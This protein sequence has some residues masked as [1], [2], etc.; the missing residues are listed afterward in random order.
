MK[1]ASVSVRNDVN[2]TTPLMES[3]S[4]VMAVIVRGE[5]P[6]LMDLIGECVISKIRAISTAVRTIRVGLQTLETWIANV[7]RGG[8]ENNVRLLFVNKLVYTASA[9]HPTNA[10]ALL[11]GLDENVKF[12]SVSQSV[13]TVLASAPTN[14]NAILDGLDHNVKQ[15]STNVS[16]T[17]EA[18]PINASTM[19]VRSSVGAKVLTL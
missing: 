11:D 8:L 7:L 3:A 17:K 1:S 10:N 16:I 4:P 19:M 14:A 2:P 12:L 18:V 6:G 15:I 5:W 9:S 13:N